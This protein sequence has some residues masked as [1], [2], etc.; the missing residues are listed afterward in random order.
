[1]KR[2]CVYVCIIVA[3]VAIAVNLNAR[4]EKTQVQPPQAFV[5]GVSGNTAA[6]GSTPDTVTTPPQNM[7]N[8]TP[9]AMT[10]LEGDRIVGERPVTQEEEKDKDSEDKGKNSPPPTSPDWLLNPPQTS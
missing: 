10:G 4:D 9:P 1:M 8:I 7:G 5:D 3:V 6:S 2:L